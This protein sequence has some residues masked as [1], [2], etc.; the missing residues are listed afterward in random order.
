MRPTSCYTR[1]Y[2]HIRR[3]SKT[4]ISDCPRYLCYFTQF[5]SA[6]IYK[7]FTT[8]HYLK[9][10]FTSGY[11][12]RN[13]SSYRT[14]IIVLYYQYTSIKS[15]IAIS[16]SIRKINRSSINNVWYKRQR[17]RSSSFCSYIRLSIRL[18]SG[19]ICIGTNCIRTICINII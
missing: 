6:R 11:R 9:R 8:M 18:S 19:R 15:S 13:T 12:H 4:R 3:R 7:D 1:T 16:I 2:V 10:L 17:Y 5:D 14:S